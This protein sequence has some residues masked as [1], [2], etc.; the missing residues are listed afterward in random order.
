MKRCGRLAQQGAFGDS[1]NKP[2]GAGGGGGGRGAAA[3]GA[4]PCVSP[5]TPEHYGREESRTHART[6][7]RA[8]PS[9]F[10]SAAACLWIFAVILCRAH[11]VLGIGSSDRPCAMAHLS[12]V[13]SCLTPSALRMSSLF[14]AWPTLNVPSA[15]VAASAVF[16]PGLSRATSRGIPPALLIA[17]LLSAFSTA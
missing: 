7:T 16:E 4:R 3:S 17:V 9:L 11:S 14:L 10:L 13:C 1:H 8:C 15:S 12:R 6:H 2:Q 5:A